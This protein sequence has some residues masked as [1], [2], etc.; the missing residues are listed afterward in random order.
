MSAHEA[1]KCATIFGAEALGFSQDIGSLEV[2]KLADLIVLDKNPLQDIRN[3]NTIRFVMKNGQLFEGD[4]LN[5]MW[6]EEKKLEK[7][8]WW[9]SDPPTNR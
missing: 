9:D 1:L 6:P 7:M 4:T 3:T 8:Y 5:Q 2:G